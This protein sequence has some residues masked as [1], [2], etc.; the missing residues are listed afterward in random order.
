[1]TTGEE[2]QHE[3]DILFSRIGEETKYVHDLI[4]E[5]KRLR[6]EIKQLKNQSNHE[7]H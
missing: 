6:E 7:S 5:N 2:L 1:M 4:E 3:G